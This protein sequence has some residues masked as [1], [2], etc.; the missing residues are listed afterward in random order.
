MMYILEQR[1][2]A[3]KIPPEKACKVWHIQHRHLMFLIIHCRTPRTAAEAAT[4]T[5][6]SLRVRR[7]SRGAF[8]DHF[9]HFNETGY[10]R[11]CAHHVQREIRQGAV[12]AT[13]FAS[14][15]RMRARVHTNT[16]QTGIVRNIQTCT[17]DVL[18]LWSASSL[19][20]IR[21]VAVDL[22]PRNC[23]A[24]LRRGRFSIASH[25]PQ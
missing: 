7:I 6:Q 22:N 13:L 11:H 20:R 21:H 16:V 18:L 25:I 2:I 10:Y 9:L 14:N 4:V 23:I 15:T 19:S 24:Q 12:R 3:Q 1:L 17:L 5:S 8:P